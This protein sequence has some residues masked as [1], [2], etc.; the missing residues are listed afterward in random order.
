LAEI[1]TKA[2]LCRGKFASRPRR[3][4]LYSFLNI[5]KGLR[6][7]QTFSWI[8]IYAFA[9]PI[10][11]GLVFILY[12]FID[13]KLTRDDE[14]FAPIFDDS[15]NVV[16]LSGEELNARKAH[17][18]EGMKQL[19]EAIAKVPVKIVNGKFVPMEGEELKAELARRKAEAEK[20]LVQITL[21][22]KTH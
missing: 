1:S 18:K 15:D 4:A 3:A 21:P 5:K 16:G 8:F 17:Q 2:F 6:D 20:N 22:E 11:F 13:F 7:M 19:S 9:L 10:F 12:K 14:K